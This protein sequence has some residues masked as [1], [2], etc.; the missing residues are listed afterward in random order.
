[1]ATSRYSP[2]LVTSQ[3]RTT[4]RK[5]SA[6]RRGPTMVITAT[7]SLMCNKRTLPQKTCTHHHQED[8]PTGHGHVLFHDPLPQECG[9]TK[10]CASDGRAP[11]IKPASG[12]DLMCLDIQRNVILTGGPD[13]SEAVECSYSKWVR[14]S[15]LVC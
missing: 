9:S 2:S 8:H 5:R 7:Y 6:F 1:M 13:S 14:P 11:P 4:H 15:I 10:S 12:Q 3:S